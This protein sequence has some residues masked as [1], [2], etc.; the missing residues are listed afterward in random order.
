MITIT[1]TTNKCDNCFQCDNWNLA[2]TLRSNGKYKGITFTCNTCQYSKKNRIPEQ[3]KTVLTGEQIRLLMVWFYN[4][5]IV[6]FV[7]GVYNENYVMHER[8]QYF[9]E[10]YNLALKNTI[11]FICELDSNNLNNLAKT[12]NNYK[13]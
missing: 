12:I 2:H 10:K 6:K 11:K 5:D 4:V 7:K 9:V 1:T 3:E 8:Q 13:G